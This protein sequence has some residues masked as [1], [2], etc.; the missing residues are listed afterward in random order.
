MWYFWYAISGVILGLLITFIAEIDASKDI[1]RPIGIV[2]IAGLAATIP[3]FI[4]GGY[5]AGIVSLV[6]YLA[7][8]HFLLDFFY[9]MEGA[10]KKKIMI[11]FTTIN[12]L[13]VVFWMVIPMLMA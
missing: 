10:K 8:V 11:S 5:V 9:S 7:V 13:W 2:L 6:V 3:R 4:F 12:V 1:M